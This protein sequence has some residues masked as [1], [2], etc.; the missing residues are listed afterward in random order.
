MAKQKLVVVG[1]GMVGHRFLAL[2][3]EGGHLDAFEVITFSEESR[4]AYDRVHLSEYF[5]GKSA[6]DLSLLPHP[7]F[8]EE[9]GIRV[10]AGDRAATIDRQTKTVVSAQGRI[11]VV[12]PGL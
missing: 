7:A 2:L 9:A 11:G 4:L 1:N 5:D 3:C 10:F 6:E 8:Y 12:Q